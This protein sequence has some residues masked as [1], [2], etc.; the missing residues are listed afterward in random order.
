MDAGIAPELVA[1]RAELER[2]LESVVSDVGVEEHPLGSGWRRELVGNELIELVQGRVA[3]ALRD[4][5]PYLAITPLDAARDP[6]AD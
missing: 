2:F 3:L 4:K 5:P 6:A 1:T